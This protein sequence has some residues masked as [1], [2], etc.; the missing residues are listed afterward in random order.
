MGKKI[1]ANITAV[2]INGPTYTD[3]TFSP[4]MIN[5]FYGKNGTG[6]STLAKAFKDGSAK[7]T[8]EGDPYPESRILIYNEDFIVKNVQSYGNIPGVFTISEVNARKKQEADEKA[9]QKKAVDDDIRAKESETRKRDKE[10]SRL[11]TEYTEAIWKAAKE[12]REKFPLALAY[13]RDKKK[14][15]DKVESLT[16]K[17]KRPDPD[18]PFFDEEDMALVSGGDEED[19]E[20]LI[21]V[22]EIAALYET[23]HGKEQ[24]SYST[25]QL[26]PSTELPSSDLL[27]KPIISRSDTEFAKFIRALGNLDWVTQGHSKYH[28]EGKK[29]PYCQQDLPPRFEEDLAACYDEQ[30]K[31]E[32]K[33][34]SAFV[35]RYKDALNAIYKAANANCQ[36]SFPTSWQAEYKAKFDV[37]MEK[38][39]ANVS[40]LEKKV[41]TPS[42][43]IELEDLT[44]LLSDLV[45]IA[46]DI[47][48]AIKEH[49]LVLADIPNQKKKCTDLAWQAIVQRTQVTT[50]TYRYNTASK[51]TAITRLQTKINELRRQ[52][53]SLATEIGKLN[54]ETVNTT[55]AMDDINKAIRS[56]GFKG[57]FLR[58][59]PGAKYVY[60]L[61]REINGKQEVVEKNL[62]EGE[63]HF[64]AFLYFY[65]MVMGSQS[66]EGKVEDKIVVID[67]PVSSM[68]SGSLFVVASL[69][70]EMIAVC[71][72]NYDMDEEKGTDDHIRQFFCMTHNPYFFREI[73]YN[74]LSDYECVSFFDI[75]KG[76][77]NQTSILECEE[78]S[79]LAGGGKVNRSPVRNTYDALWYEY[80]TTDDPETLMIVIRQILEYYFIQM[81]GYS[82]GNLRKDLLDKN[83]KEFVKDL[84]DGSQDRNDYVAA[85]AMIAMLNVGATGFN[86]GLYYDS[87]AADITQLRSVFERIFKVMGQEQHYDMMTRR[88]K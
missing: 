58:E 55:K 14:F 19:T 10:K 1:R 70:R 61:V 46:R 36:N 26:F 25:Y 39:R 59:K 20:P 88:A 3:V 56:A 22:E 35:Q 6:K 54:S 41:A 74:R 63:R 44:E 48:A 4:S 16:P 73:T 24:P 62:S 11:Y 42:E 28:T 15:A 81:V 17:L 68:D 40:L 71:Y 84:E 47:N 78:D 21:S 29:C 27:A 12:F 2:K 87:S 18:A 76:A 85:A 86:D 37:F 75:K 45:E 34:L 13:L 30:Y 57:F 66:D 50:N 64:I 23:V 31:D 7:L 43:E 69:V 67:D 38:A 9:A 80:A 5:F 60:Q 32:V 83:E 8:W 79:K 51:Q 33:K 77:D 53:N 72:N 52:S 82:N 49:N 65:H